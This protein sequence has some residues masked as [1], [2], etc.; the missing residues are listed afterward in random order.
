MLGSLSLLKDVP[1]SIYASFFDLA[2]TP[3]K[4]V[5]NALEILDY[6]LAGKVNLSQPVN[7]YALD[8]MFSKYL[9][10]NV[11][12]NIPIIFTEDDSELSQAYQ[13]GNVCIGNRCTALIV[14]DAYKELLDEDELDSTIQALKK[15]EQELLIYE[16]V[17]I[18]DMLISAKRGIKASVM[19]LKNLCEKYES[20]AE[21][22][23]IVLSS[24]TDLE[25]LLG[26]YSL[27]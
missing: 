7:L 16:N 9:D 8:Y 23:K 24:G 17:S 27:C 1:Y 26:R 10:M 15:M 19:T 11:K 21:Y 5:V 20:L 12:K 6:T 22:V 25:E 4:S 14:K 2:K 18:F 3:N 13:K